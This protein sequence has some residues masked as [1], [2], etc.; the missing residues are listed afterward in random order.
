[1]ISDA[2]PTIGAAT[3]ASGVLRT[4]ASQSA[5]VPLLPRLALL[6]S[7]AAVTAGGT[8]LGLKAAAG[9]S[10][11]KKLIDSIKTSEITN[12]TADSDK[13]PSPDD[14]NFSIKSILED[15]ELDIPLLTILEYILTLNIYELLLILILVVLLLRNNLLIFSFLFL[16]K[17]KAGKYTSKI[18]IKYTPKIYDFLQKTNF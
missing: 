12:S 15:G 2:A 11:N 9:L 4:I 1:M 6:G 18:L 7:S 8:A 13:I 3:V 17:K 16:L 14:I 10:K 5:N